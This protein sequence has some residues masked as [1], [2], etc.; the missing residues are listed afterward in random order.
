MEAQERGLLEAILTDPD[1]D[2]ARLVYADWLE[3]HGSR[4]RVFLVTMGPVA[5][6]TARATYSKNFFEAGGFE[7][8][9]IRR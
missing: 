4:P 8:V 2:S 7:V 1:N 6:Y 5:H 9:E 3:E